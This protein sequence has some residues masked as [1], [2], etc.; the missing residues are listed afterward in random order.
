MNASLSVLFPHWVYLR[1]FYGVSNGRWFADKVLVLVSNSPK[2]SSLIKTVL[3]AI[4][5]SQVH[6][7]RVFHYREG[8]RLSQLDYKQ[9]WI[10]KM[11]NETHWKYKIEYELF[12]VIFELFSS[13][14]RA[15]FE[16]FLRSFLCCFRAVWKAIKMDCNVVELKNDLQ[17]V[18]SVKLFH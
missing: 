4:N 2:R 8:Q 18:F 7:F 14:F 15:V 13:R 10:Y 5:F 12:C 11:V 17:S 9:I 16:L 3:K 1:A 6:E